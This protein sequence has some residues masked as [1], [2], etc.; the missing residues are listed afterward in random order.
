M[1][2]IEEF[3]QL[4][5]LLLDILEQKIKARFKYQLNQV[6]KKLN[7]NN[8]DNTKKKYI[9]ITKEEH[10]VLNSF[11]TKYLK[12]YNNQKNMDLFQFQQVENDIFKM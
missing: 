7:N 10:A 12:E 8:N 5:K 9:H 2:K 1:K 6:R 11:E 4:Q 3:H